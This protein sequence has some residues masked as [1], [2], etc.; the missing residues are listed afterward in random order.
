MEQQQFD[1]QGAL[2]RVGV[3]A[4]EIRRSEAYPALLGGIAGGIA[5]ALMAVLIAGRVASSKR[6]EKDS[7]AEPKKKWSTREIVQLATVVAAL[8]KQV[9]SWNEERKR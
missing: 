1:T 2:E 6:V 8:A 5:G 3:L 9:Q 4:K 7:D